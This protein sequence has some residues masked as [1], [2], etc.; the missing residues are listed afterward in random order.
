MSDEYLTGTPEAVQ[1]AAN[2]EA[3]QAAVQETLAAQATAPQPAPAPQPQVTYQQP[4]PQPQVKYQAPPTPPTNNQRGYGMPCPPPKKC[5]GLWWKIVMLV[6]T[7]LIA[8]GVILTTINSY[9]MKASLEAIEENSYGVD[10]YDYG[11]PGY[12]YDNGYDDDDNYYGSDDI[13]DFFSGI[14]GDG[15]GQQNGQGN[16]NRQG[17]QGNYGGQ[18]DDEDFDMDDVYD[19]F[20]GIFGGEKSGSQGF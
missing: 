17:N 6:L 19:F 3:A 16:Q 9:E 11:Y 8:A 4:A 12:Y 7:A 5:S 18:E 10:Y 1:V 2:V 13:S 20:S 14:F 15:N